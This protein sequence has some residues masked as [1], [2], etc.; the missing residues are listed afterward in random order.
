M[1]NQLLVSRES[2]TA[3]FAVKQLLS[4]LWHGYG[5]TQT[6]GKLSLISYINSRNRTNLD[7]KFQHR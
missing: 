5:Q 3:R 7:N 6:L 1:S 4:Y 2:Y